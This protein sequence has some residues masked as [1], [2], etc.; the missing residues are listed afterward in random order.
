MSALA[1][2]GLYQVTVVM[3]KI[4]TKITISIAALLLFVA[5][6]PLFIIR[7]N[8]GR[9]VHVLMYH[10]FNDNP[11]KDVWTVSTSEFEEQMKCLKNNNFTPIL[12]HQIALAAKGLYVL[13][14]KPVI[15]TMDDGFRNN[16]LIAEPIMRKYGMK[17][18][19]YLIMSH[20]EDTEAQRSQYRSNDNLIWP[21]VREAMKR[22]TLTFGVHSISHSSDKFRQSHEVTPAR[23]LFRKKTGIKTKSYCYPHGLAP[24]ILRDAVKNKKRYSTA[25]VCDDKVFSFSVK[26]DLYRIPRVSVYG[27]NHSFSL[28]S[29]AFENHRLTAR[30]IN[31]GVTLPLTAVLRDT[32]SGHCY[33]NQNQPVRIGNGSYADFSWDGL[34]SDFHK[35]HAEILLYEQNFLFTYGQPFQCFCNEANKN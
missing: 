9:K 34:P 20:I 5:L 3:A 18:I 7:I 17:G 29:V 35:E 27:G 19:C 16:V 12:P 4:K 30:I 33:R 15:I 22:G 21:E 10:G 8:E 26:A 14:S 25:M 13:P 11:G 28:N 23:Y 6:V 24:D 32:H 2:C 31:T 1:P